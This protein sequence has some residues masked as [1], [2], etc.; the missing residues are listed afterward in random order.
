MGA[1]ICV[2]IALVWF[3]GM[4]GCAF[5][6]PAAPHHPVEF[7]SAPSPHGAEKYP[8]WAMPPAIDFDELAIAERERSVYKVESVEGAGSGTTGAEEHTIT[9]PDVAGDI[10]FKVKLTPGSLD[11]INNSPRKEMAAYLI[12][13][14]FLDPQD[15]VVPTTFAYCIGI[16]EWRKEH[17]GKGSPNVEGLNCAL[18]V[19]ALWMKDVTLPDPLYDE[20]RFLSDPNYAYF[21]SN[22][23]VFT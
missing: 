18:G 2:A 23:N 20:Q 10:E 5:F 7:R 13:R 3:T 15:F 21:L 22:F 4:L 12:Q 6:S 8:N 1:R 19:S 14:F 16:E 11:G 9:L 17:G